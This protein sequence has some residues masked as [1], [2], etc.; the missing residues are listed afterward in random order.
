MSLRN[1]ALLL[2][3][4]QVLADLFTHADLVHGQRRV[5]LAWLSEVE[6]LLEESY[7][8]LR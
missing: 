7:Y 5:A 1:V 8:H 4:S 3:L 6:A 2:E